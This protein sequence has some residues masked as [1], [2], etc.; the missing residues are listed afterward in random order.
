[1]PVTD[2]TG[3]RIL[4]YNVVVPWVAQQENISPDTV[5]VSRT[6][7]DAPPTGYD[8][9]TGTYSRMCDQISVSITNA[10]Q[11]TLTLS[12]DWRGKNQND[13]IADFINAVAILLLAA[14]M[15]ATGVNA[16]TWVM[17]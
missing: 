10:E 11:R 1:M 4:V 6:F 16:H 13:V 8:F 3:A 9:D 15:T 14:P 7:V 12:G 2:P 17:S 5:D